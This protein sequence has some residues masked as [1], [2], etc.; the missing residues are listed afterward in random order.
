MSGGLYLR[1]GVQCGKF[2]MQTAVQP[3]VWALRN[4][5]MACGIATAQ[6]ATR[7]TRSEPIPNQPM[8]LQ[9]PLS[10]QSRQAIPLAATAE[11]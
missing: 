11:T 2:L 8:N 10:T 4:S 6:T 5:S 3:P 7:I 1:V 9:L